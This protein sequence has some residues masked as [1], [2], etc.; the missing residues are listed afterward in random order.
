MDEIHTS[1]EI[2]E[3]HT[4]ILS[5]TKLWKNRPITITPLHGGI[6]NKNYLVRSGFAE[7]VARFAFPRNELLDINRK[8]EVFNTKQ[9][10]R[11]GLGPEFVDHLPKYRLLV[12]RF[13]EGAPLSKEVA[14]KS[15]TIAAV[16]EMLRKLHSSGK[17]FRGKR[18]IFHNIEE[19]FVR[20]G[21]YSSWV[22]D[23]IAEY[24]GILQE[25]ETELCQ[26]VLAPCHFDLMLENIICTPSGELKLIDWEYSA[27]GDGR[28]DIA[29]FALKASLEEPNENLLLETYN[30]SHSR[31]YIMPRELQLMKA[32]VCLREASWGV[33]QNAISEM[34]HEF[35]YKEYAEKHLALF[36]ELKRKFFM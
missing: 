8:R 28:F 19:Y 36:N 32:V 7:Y 31:I 20:A 13:I 26:P 21:L 25:I 30:K 34:K 35:N 10:A 15:E 24:M 9:A 3:K 23:N 12:V 16:G 2:T 11:L 29:M 6:T 14:R 17:R 1:S 22:P 27:Q 5:R 18:N 33:L 4:R